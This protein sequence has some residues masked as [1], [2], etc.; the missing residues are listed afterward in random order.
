MMDQSEPVAGSVEEIAAVCAQVRC[1]VLVVQGTRDNCQP[2]ERGVRTAELTGAPRGVLEGSGHIPM[3]RR[4][5]KVNQLISD[6]A[7]NGAAAEPVV[8]RGRRGKRAL[9]VSSPIGLGQD[10]RDEP[11]QVGRAHVWTAG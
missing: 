4:P 11:D 7:G 8:H 1:P 2:F 6:F 10:W 3:A 9:L 5:V